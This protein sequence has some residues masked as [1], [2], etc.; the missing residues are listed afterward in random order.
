MILFAQF[1]LFLRMN[2]KSL[3]AT[4]VFSVLLIG[5]LKAQRFGGNPT[6][7]KFYQLNTD[8]VRIIFPKGLEKQARE[9]A[10][11]SHQLVRDSSAS[12]LGNK[13]RKFNV[14]LQNQ[15]TTSNAYVGPAPWR[16][17]FYMMPDL[18]NLGSGSISWHQYLALHEFR[19]IEQFSNFN[20]T[21]PKIAGF[22][23]G[24]EGQA[25]AMNLAVPDW[26]WEGDAVWQE[27]MNSKQGRGRFP[28]FF[29]S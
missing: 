6:S 5:Q 1:N 19:H 25:V 24:Q 8:T 2:R 29:N 26:F 22:F 17:E 27:T 18:S 21:I 3:L 13:L 23:F 9:A 16:S 14:V 11:L 15:T 4:I 20:R 12:S 28:S 7:L 10:W